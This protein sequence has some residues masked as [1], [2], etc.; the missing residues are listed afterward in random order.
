MSV[1]TILAPARPIGLAAPL[2]A[3]CASL[4]GG[5][6]V[7][8]ILGTAMLDTSDAGW[9]LA[10]PLGWDPTQYHLAWRF[11]A[12]APWQWPP[13]L[14][15]DYG[16]ELAGGIFH[17]D[18]IP[19]LAL[20]MKLLAPGL[21][22]YWGPWLLACGVLQ[23][24]FG[25]VLMGHATRHPVARVLGAGLLLLQPMLLSRM[26]GHLALA[27][28]FTLLAALA[29]ALR[30]GAMPRRQGLLWAV[31]LAA[32]ALI[33]AYLL[34]MVAAVWAADWLRRALACWRAALLAEALALPG[35]C[36][37]ALWLCGFFSILG[38]LGAPGYGHMMLDLAAPFDR[39]DWGLF[40]PDLPSEPHPE[41]GDVYLGLGGLGLLLLGA[42]C[43][44]GRG[45][46]RRHWPLLAAVLAMLGF[47]VSHN[48]TLLGHSVTLFELPSWFAATAGTLRASERFAW[49]ALYLALVLAMIS[50]GRRL[51]GAQAALALGLLLAVQVMD[52]RPGLARLHGV[53][54]QAQAMPAAGFHPFW[55]EA[56]IRYWRIR[57]VPAANLG[58]DWKPIATIAA[59][60]RMATD[61]VY[62]A[63]MDPVAMARLQQEMARRLQEARHEPGTL[64][65]LRD[66]PSLALARA[67]MDPARDMLAV[68]DGMQ[69][70]APGWSVGRAGAS[71]PAAAARGP[72]PP[73]A[74]YPPPP[75]S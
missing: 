73:A 5:A 12:Q 13:G 33:H 18:A 42:A 57:A 20:P 49:P 10:G 24:F 43:A 30:A 65:V 53:M 66:A 3:A 38:G 56:R 1:S 23:G 25:W 19:L 45:V 2:S 64:Y 72:A 21:A 44:A 35:G 69:V 58:T 31:L 26:G 68:I 8:A 9:M 34:A 52:L 48:A 15:P 55:T 67:A 63:R 59:Q 32:T 74:G 17:A 75:P 11:F 4:L 7:L 28:Q 61:A 41:S 29:L 22:Q 40:L 37:L 39:G 47:A 60:H 6:M 14:N 36:A 62:L 54:A 46:P 51:S 70:L 16:L 27:G 71:T 50:L